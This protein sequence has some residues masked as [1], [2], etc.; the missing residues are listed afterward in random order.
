[1]WLKKFVYLD[2]LRIFMSE[3]SPSFVFLVKPTHFGF[4]PE[5]ASSNSFQ[6]QLEMEDHHQVMQEFSQVLEILRRE[7][8]A[9][10]VFDSVPEK[11]TPDAVFPN[12]WICI[13]PDG[14]LVLFPMLTP[15]RRAERNMQ[16][17]EELRKKFEI[18]TI[19]DLSPAEENNI[20]LEGTGSIVFDH[21]HRKAYTCISPRTNEKLV[22]ELCHRIDYTPIV[23]EALGPKAEQVYHTNVVMNIGSGYA[24]VC[25][26]AI[27]DPL[28]ASMVRKHLEA[29]QIQVIP[30]SIQQM[31][32]FC[33]NMLEVK[34]KAGEKCLL[35]SET[36]LKHLEKNQLAALPADI[37]CIA[38]PIPLIEKIGG[39]SL[40]CMLAGIHAKLRS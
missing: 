14:T 20:A 11:I 27:S 4:N 10:M 24:F 38:F 7:N 25:L 5:T 12:N 28:E 40:R 19:I 30:I 39:G 16:V 9:Y 37:K 22:R 18:T 1:M 2:L 35:L 33:G 23:F 31:S 32:A 26:D 17:V 3:Q 36:A 8:I 6:Q 15:N 13:Q 21:V 34:N 29:D